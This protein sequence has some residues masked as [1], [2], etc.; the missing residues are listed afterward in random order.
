MARPTKA[1]NESV[2]R[3][4]GYLIADSFNV[5]S[6]FPVTDSRILCASVAFPMV[7]VIEREMGQAWTWRI[8]IEAA[9]QRY[10]ERTSAAQDAPGVCPACRLELDARNRCPDGP[11]C[12]TDPTDKVTDD[13][14]PAAE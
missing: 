9:R 8:L 3:G 4:I 6:P 10:D 5:E 7:T 2:I 13:N 12:G 11:L 14:F 1:Q